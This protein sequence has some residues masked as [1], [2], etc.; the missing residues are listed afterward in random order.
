M[1]SLVRSIMIGFIGGAI[2]FSWLGCTHKSGLFLRN[3][4]FV[5]PNSN[6]EPIGHV[7]ASESWA[8]LFFPQRIG[9]DEINDVVNTALRGKGGN[10]LINYKM[11]VAVTGFPI[12]PLYITELTVDG[13]AAKMTIGR[14][15]LR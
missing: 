1:K 14:Q 11:T 3:S 7:F 12:I 5:Y 9:L 10:L 8:T 2:I 15:E 4:K 13:T 6:V